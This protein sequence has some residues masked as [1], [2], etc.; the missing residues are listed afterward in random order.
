M[1]RYNEI[2]ENAR[3]SE[4]A[5]EAYLV[6][7]AEAHGGLALKYSNVNQTGYPDRLLIL[8]HKPAVWVELKSKGKKPRPLQELRHQQL[9]ELGQAVYVADSREKVD[10]II[11]NTLYD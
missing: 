1:K 6:K 3:V 10:E 8:P 11:N 9:R 2:A 5:I 7:Q 4:K